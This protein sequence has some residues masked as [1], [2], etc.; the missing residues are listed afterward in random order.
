MAILTFLKGIFST[1]KTIDIAVETGAK[2]TDGIIAGIDVSILTK[3]EKIQYTH[4][5]KKLVLEFWKTIAGENTQ[6]SIAR[7]ELT[8]M[9]FKVYLSLCL[10]AV[11]VYPFSIAYATFILL[12]MKELF[13]LMSSI[14]VI[15]FGPQQLSK[16]KQK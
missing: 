15:Y 8:K 2:I 9:V 7:R 12:L 14:A 1:K 3:E 6:Q 13:W 11:A 4:E 16:L 5:G 10:M